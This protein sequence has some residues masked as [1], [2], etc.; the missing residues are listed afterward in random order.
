MGVM[1]EAGVPVGFFPFQRSGAM[2][3]GV[4]GR[5]CEFQGIIAGSD[6]GLN[7]VD[8][9]RGCG[10]RGWHFDHLV[11]PRVA[12]DPH[13]WGL[14]DSPYIDLSGGFDAY[15]AA[16][17][18]A[19][20][21]QIVQVSRKAR[22]IEREVGPLRFEFHTDDRRALAALLAWKTQQHERTKRI[23]VFRFDW[24][25][26]VLERI[27]ATGSLG[28]SRILSAL[29]AGDR[30]IAVHLGMR[31]DKV[32]HWWFPAFD[33]D[34]AKYSPGS[35]LL[36]ELAKVARDR[37][38]SRIDLGKGEERYKRSF[39]TGATPL[40]EGLVHRHSEIRVLRQKWCETKRWLRASPGRARLEAPL[41]PFR[42]AREFLILR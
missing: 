20:S 9:V 15:F 6:L 30:L 32:L 7:P 38:L 22:K 31:S 42:W 11:T 12:F 39:M 5:L 18:R 27:W 13:Q 16:R 40:G 10:L 25:V 28:F 3:R 24:I 14:S 29:Y 36:V 37:G 21:A 17:R 26:R 19:G 1:V 23:P 41:R 4:G 2:A 33:R 35:I 8:L 34:Y